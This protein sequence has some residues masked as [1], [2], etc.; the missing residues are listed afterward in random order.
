MKLIS[1]DTTENNGKT[2]TDRL[3]P[4]SIEKVSSDVSEQHRRVSVITQKK[5]LSDLAQSLGRKRSQ[6]DTTDRSI[7]IQ[8]QEN[9]E[10]SNIFNHKENEN[11]RYSTLDVITAD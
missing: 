9:H 11:Y 3:E 6:K 2:E 8:T 7:T 5:L 1:I 10:D 4:E